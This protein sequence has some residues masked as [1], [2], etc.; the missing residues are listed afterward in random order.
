VVAKRPIS[1]LPNHLFQELGWDFF[2]SPDAGDYLS[3]E[4]LLLR[5]A[6]AETYYA[7]GIRLYEL[8]CDAAE[9]VIAENAF[10]VLGI[11]ANLIPL[12]VQSWEDSRHLHLMGR[13]DFAGGTGGLPIR[14]IEFNADTPTSLPETAIIQ[15]ASL[16]A[17]GLDED[18]QFNTLYDALTEQFRTLRQMNEDLEPRLLFSTLRHAPEDE[19]NVSVLMEAAREAGFEVEFAYV[20]GVTFSA[21]EGIFSGNAESGWKQCP[22]WFKLIPWEY[23]AYDEPALAELLTE[24]VGRRLAVVMN[25]AYSLLFQT[26]GILK[27]LSDLH[28]EE[29]LLLKTSFRRPSNPGRGYVEKV[30]FGREGSN[31]IIYGPDGEPLSERGGEYGHYPSVFQDRA[32]LASDPDGYYYQAGLFFAGEPAG[33]GFRRSRDLIMDDRSQFVGH[34][35]E[36]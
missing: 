9:F 28:P 11:P 21:S 31:V 12:I 20:D 32:T 35:V 16:K 10:E 13:F 18:R 33:L 36:G 2:V 29:P 14:L 34:Y 4:L 17:N 27:V 30:F 26:K 6:E 19:H 23:I 8:F 1:Q 5:E 24:I 3:S 7:A 22:F 25:P 15:W